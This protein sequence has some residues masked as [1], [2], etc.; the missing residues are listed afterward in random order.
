MNDDWTRKTIASDFHNAFSITVPNMAPGFAYAVYPNGY[1][2]KERAHIFVAGDGDHS[3]HVLY[4]TGDK[5]SF[6]YDDQIFDNAKS[7]VGCLAFS[8]LDE[9]G[10]QEVWVPAYDKST[11]ELFKMSSASSTQQPEIVTE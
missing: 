5:D 11:I 2:A 8:D 10:W 6:E 9:D 3:A 1:H 4:P 7:T